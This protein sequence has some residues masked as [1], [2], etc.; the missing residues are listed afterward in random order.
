MFE[1]GVIQH[2]TSSWNSPLFLDPKKKGQILPVIDFRRVNEVTE[3]DRYPLPVLS[4]PPMNLGQ[5]NTIFFSLEL[6]FGYWQVHM[7][8]EACASAFLAVT[9]SGFAC[10]SA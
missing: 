9:S 1:Q 10:S 5:G 2:S 3:D 4:D 6:L 8:P 7:G